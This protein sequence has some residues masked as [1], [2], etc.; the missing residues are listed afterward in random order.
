MEGCPSKHLHCE[1]AIVKAHCIT[2]HFLFP[3]PL[4]PSVSLSL[5][6]FQLLIATQSNPKIQGSLRLD[7]PSCSF[8]SSSHDIR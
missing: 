1:T 4:F 5:W 7:S 3:F 8:S 6:S 2:L